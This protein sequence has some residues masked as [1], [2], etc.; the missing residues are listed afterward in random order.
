[1]TW[2]RG[3]SGSWRRVLVISQAERVKVCV[4]V[5]TG[6]AEACGAGRFGGEDCLESPPRAGRPREEL[7][8]P[9]DLG[10]DDLCP[11]DLD[12]VGLAPG[13]RR[14]ALR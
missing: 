1:M 14:P 4:L 5:D 13:D 7:F 11:E 6:L 9:D 12:P 8:C 10:P 3:E 2:P